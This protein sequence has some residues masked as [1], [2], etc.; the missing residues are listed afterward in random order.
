MIWLSLRN[1]IEVWSRQNWLKQLLPHQRVPEVIVADRSPTLWGDAKSCQKY[2]LIGRII[3]VIIII[4]IIIIRINIAAIVVVVLLS[5]V[6]TLTII[7]IYIYQYH[8]VEEETSY[9]SIY[10]S[11]EK[12][13]FLRHVTWTFPL[14]E[15]WKKKSETYGP[16]SPRCEASQNERCS[17]KLFAQPAL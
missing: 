16:Y 2:S 17:T 7:Y 11:R 6:I 4:S 14:T 10:Q 9:E 3:I 1:N 8:R 15:F 13:L 5:I 12:T